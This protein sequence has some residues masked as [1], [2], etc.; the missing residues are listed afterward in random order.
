M[1]NHFF[2][3]LVNLLLH[4]SGLILLLCSGVHIVWGI[5]HVFNK[6]LAQ[7]PNHD[8]YSMITRIVVWSWY[9]GAI[10]GNIFAAFAIQ[11]LRKSIIY[12]SILGKKI[13]Q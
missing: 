11:K 10:G 8:S 13:V 4:F 3:F 9:V 12:V 1:K 5:Y 2:F 6:R 7:E